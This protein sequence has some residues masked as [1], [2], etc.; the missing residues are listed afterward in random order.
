MEIQFETLDN[1]F[2]TFFVKPIQNKVDAY[3]SK[4]CSIYYENE[5]LIAQDKLESISLLNNFFQLFS[6]C[7]YTKDFINKSEDNSYEY[8]VSIYNTKNCPPPSILFLSP[9][10]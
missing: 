9:F 6:F 3:L 10:H 5:I 1:F 7:N 8:K 2:N 4:D